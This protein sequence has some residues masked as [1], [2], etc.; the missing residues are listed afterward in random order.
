MSRRIEDLAE[1]LG[2]TVVGEVPDFSA[3]AFGMAQLAHTLRS[4]LQ[5]GH[6][7]RPGRPSNPNWSKRTKIPLAEVTEGRLKQLARALSDEHRKISPMQVAAQLLE[8]ATA[9]Y[10]SGA[11]F[12][13]D[14]PL[15]KAAAVVAE[16][17]AGDKQ[18]RAPAGRGEIAREILEE[19]D[20]IGRQQAA[21]NPARR[22]SKGN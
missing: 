14:L 5:P 11:H 13:G 3:G 7:K 19:A 15:L 8:E 17:G 10:F 18:S 21:P 4:R 16:R 9:S 20:R 22:E 6:G 2:A 1:K 12:P